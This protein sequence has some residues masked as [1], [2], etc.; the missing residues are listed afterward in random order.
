MLKVSCRDIFQT[1]K[2]KLLR[3]IILLGGSGDVSK[4][5]RNVVGEQSSRTSR[6]APWLSI[7][8]DTLEVKVRES[9][10]H[11]SSRFTPGV[12]EWCWVDAYTGE[13]WSGAGKYNPSSQRVAS[14]AEIFL[15]AE[16]IRYQL[17]NDISEQLLTDIFEKSGSLEDQDLESTTALARSLQVQC[18]ELVGQVLVLLRVLVNNMSATMKQRRVDILNKAKR[19]P[20]KGGGNTGLTNV[21]YDGESSLQSAVLL[22]TRLAW[23]LRS[24]QGTFL[25]Y[26]LQMQQG[27]RN[28]MAPTSPRGALSNFTSVHMNSH[29]QYMTSLDQ[30]QSAFDI[31]DTDG[32]G[33]IT[34]DEAVEVCSLLL[35]SS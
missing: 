29:Q 33:I 8:S 10:G 35:L 11:L 5:Q 19:S 18:C 20:E 1:T 2:K 3:T 13:K 26:S 25:E 14:S 27:A 17:E 28:N 21:A 30:L 4:S 23:L 7:D 15:A 12:N 34:F 32:D 24:S 9:D 6:G 16:S 31:A 22:L